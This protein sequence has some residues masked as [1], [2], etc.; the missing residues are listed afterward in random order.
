MG[1]VFFKNL[2]LMMKFCYLYYTLLLWDFNKNIV[3]IDFLKV[4]FRLRY[5]LSSLLS[6]KSLIFCL[7][8]TI[9]Y[10]IFKAIISTYKVETS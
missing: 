1:E 5:C 10:F 4:F 3:E 7:K 9:T 2:Y 6:L 8:I